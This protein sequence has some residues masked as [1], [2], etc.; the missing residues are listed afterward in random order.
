MKQQRLSY[1]ANVSEIY[2]KLLRNTKLRKGTL[3]IMTQI[4][5]DLSIK[6]VCFSFFFFF[7]TEKKFRK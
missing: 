2:L 3:I 7:I 1:Y 6:K 5:I 4:F